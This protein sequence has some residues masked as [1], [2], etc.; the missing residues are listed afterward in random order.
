MFIWDVFRSCLVGLRCLYDFI[1]SIHIIHYV[2]I[3]AGYFSGWFMN[4]IN[5]VSYNFML[6]TSYSHWRY[7]SAPQWWKKKTIS[8]MRECKTI[9]YYTTLHNVAFVHLCWANASVR[10]LMLLAVDL[11]FLKNIHYEFSSGHITLCMMMMMIMYS[12]LLLSTI[13]FITYL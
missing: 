8:S 12:E 4:I 9:H 1:V 11:C 10:Y 2:Y 13:V 7:S 6:H 3:F 5:Q